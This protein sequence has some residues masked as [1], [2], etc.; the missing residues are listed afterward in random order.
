MNEQ[1][2]RN[3]VRQEIQRQSNASQFRLGN[4]QQHTHNG[5]D[6]PLVREENLIP[7]AS[8]TGF[9]TFAQATTYTIQLN[10][11]FTP[12]SITVY[13]IATGEYSSNQ[14]RVLSFGTAQLTPTFY[15]Q[16]PTDAD[17]PDTYVV[18]GKKQFPFSTSGSSS[19]KPAQSSSFLSVT[20]G[21][22]SNFYA[23]VSEDHIM[24]V[25]LPTSADSDIKA[26]ATITDFSKTAITVDIPILASG[27]EITLNFVIT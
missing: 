24:S 18:T 3:I 26:R 10:A 13:G 16:D 19:G 12:R 7:S 2:I 22:T 11:S 4:V 27:W 15:L 6:S 1:Q 14:T 20:R 17:T 5:T 21:G 8:I 23:G 9:V 25:F